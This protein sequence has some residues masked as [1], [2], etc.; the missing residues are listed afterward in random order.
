MANNVPVVNRN[1]E[2]KDIPLSVDKVFN[3]LS[4]VSG[5]TKISLYR[6]ALI[7]Y[8]ENHKKDLA[9]FTNNLTTTG[10]PDA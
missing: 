10:A 1:V 7:E 2:L 8:A 5:K 3:M 6:E 4:A 9:E